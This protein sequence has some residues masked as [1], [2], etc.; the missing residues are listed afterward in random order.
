MAVNLSPYGGVGAQFFSNNG[1]PL[2]GGKIFTYAAGTT[3]PQATYT[4]ASGVTAHA[5]PIILDAAGRVPG[6]EI[7]LT[8]GL[9]YKFVL[10]D[11]ND[12]T[13]ATYD[14]VVGINSNFVNYTNEQEIQTATA[15]QTVF[16]LTTMQY[17]PGTGSLSVFVDGV[18]QYGP[19]AQYAFLETNSITVTFISGL[20][21]G[22]QVKFTTSQL[23]NASSVD[24]SQVS[25]EPPFT[26]SVS[27]NVEAKLAQTVSVK[28]F[29]AVGDGVTDDFLAINRAV[30]YVADQGGG[31]VYYPPGTYRITRSI[32]LD[33]FNVDTNTYSG[34]VRQNI[35]HQGAGRDS[36]IIK[37]D[38]F[39]ACAFTS[40]PEPF[41]AGGAIT[42]VPAPPNVMCSNVVI[43][44][45]TLDGNKNVVGDGGTTY[46]LNYQTSPEATGGW[47]NGYVGPSYWASDNYQFAIHL[48]YG[49]R[50]LVQNVHIKDW[51]YAGVLGF[52][53]AR[54]EIH[55]NFIE[56]CGDVATVLGYY[57]ALEFDQ[58]TNT[59]SATDNIIQNCG[60]GVFSGTGTGATSPCTDIEISNNIFYGISPGNGI[61]ARDF[62]SRW[63]VAD[64]VFDDIGGQGIVFVNEQPGWPATQLPKNI[65]ITGN[66]INEFNL[67]NGAGSAGISVVGHQFVIANNTIT[68]TNGGVTNPTFAIRTNDTIVTVSA[69]ERKGMVVTGNMISGK[70]PN[71]SAGVGILYIDSE[72]TLVSNNQIMSNG[73]AAQT[74]ITLLNTNA[75]VKGNNILGT[76]VQGNR[77]IYDYPGSSN[78]YVDDNRYG[79]ITA[80]HTTVVSGSIS[81]SNNVDFSGLTTVVD[82]DNRANYDSATDSITPDLPGVYELTATLR[83]TAASASTVQGAIELNNVTT[84]ATAVQSAGA[85]DVVT[86]TLSGF[87]TLSGSDVV[88]LK[89][90]VSAG[91]YVVESFTSLSAKFVRQTT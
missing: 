17:Q 63:V 65:S 2:A 26:N 24:A 3:T 39:Y 71:S 74:A 91:N 11:A 45:M 51:W 57:P 40:F 89:A 52:A 55:D 4:S 29:G 33:D 88:R 61:Y 8:D 79:A 32:R 44:D 81:G 22:A 48:Y 20:H 12:I 30:K 87:A 66:I 84:V 83:V 14:N 36:T 42:P 59:V 68:Q 28:D 90:N 13:L 6:G 46:G 62:Q 70:F 15:G 1:V 5:N 78:M 50:L 38:G 58:R 25:Y 80:I 21:I 41:I 67:L 64:N 23:N 31:T 19:G 77:A 53:S 82:I 9:Q 54:M 73:S 43:K 69:N 86:V 85:G 35:V 72:N 56:T 75:V 16:T 18:N 76:Y 34:N 60:N 7:W 10:K 49:E 27:T 47:P 37:T